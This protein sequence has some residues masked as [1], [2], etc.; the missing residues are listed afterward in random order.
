MCDSKACKLQNGIY[1]LPNYCLVE[2]HV[3][4]HIHDLNYKRIL[5]NIQIL[6]L[7]LFSGTVL[8]NI[9]IFIS[10]EIEQT[11]KKLKDANELS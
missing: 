10:A 1:S 7:R 6:K 8:I 4:L 2:F 9:F 5:C 11:I 3:N